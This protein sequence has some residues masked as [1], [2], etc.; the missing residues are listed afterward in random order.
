MLLAAAASGGEVGTL[1]PLAPGAG[2]FLD[3]DLNDYVEPG[4]Q[5]ELRLN[6]HDKI[7]SH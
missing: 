5:F 1:E 2:D 4:R 7:L 3:A 6:Q